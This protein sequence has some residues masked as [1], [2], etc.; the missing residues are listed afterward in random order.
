M[1]PS[2]VS[3]ILYREPYII[4]LVVLN[5]SELK[6]NSLKIQAFL[7]GASH[8]QWMVTSQSLKRTFFLV[9]TWYGICCT[10]GVRSWTLSL[11]VWSCSAVAAIGTWRN[12]LTPSFLKSRNSKLS[13]SNVKWLSMDTLLL[14]DVIESVFLNLLM[15]FFSLSKYFKQNHYNTPK[16]VFIFSK[17]YTSQNKVFSIILERIQWNFTIDLQAV[18]T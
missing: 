15:Y 4:S 12:S 17:G 13:E 9:G 16:A 14:L 5:L 2:I 6:E 18:C 1:D 11:V 7:S 10:F 8:Y 3:K